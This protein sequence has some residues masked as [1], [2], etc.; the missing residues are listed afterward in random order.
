M[1][2]NIQKSQE[3]IF[4]RSIKQLRGVFSS[5][6]RYQNHEIIREAAGKALAEEIEREGKYEQNEA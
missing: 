3:S 2:T 4:R 5:E 6:K 1:G